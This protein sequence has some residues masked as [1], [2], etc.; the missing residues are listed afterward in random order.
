MATLEQLQAQRQQLIQRI[1]ASGGKAGNPGLVQ[2]LKALDSEIRSTR[3]PERPTSTVKDVKQTQANIAGQAG[4]IAQ[5]Y[6]GQLGGPFQYELGP[7][8]AQEQLLA[9]RNRIEQDALARLTQNLDRDEGRERARIEQELF[10]RGIPFSADP[11]SRYQQELGANQERF[12]RARQ[13]AGQ[14]ATEVG[15]Q[16]YAQYVQQQEQIRANRGGEQLGQRTQQLGEIGGLSTLGVPG[17]ISFQELAEQ[18]AQRKA[19]ERIARGDQGT[20]LQVAKIRSAPPP[21]PHES[22]FSSGQYPGYSGF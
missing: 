17:T 5:D 6:L 20:A 18:A 2:R 1:Q 16:E 19:Q 4:G 14:R 10:N 11:N 8:L 21:P 22:P 13:E 9:E 7:G 3:G 15:G 12:D